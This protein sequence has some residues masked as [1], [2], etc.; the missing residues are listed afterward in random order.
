MVETVRHRLGTQQGAGV[1]NEENQP[2]NSDL[3][4]DMKMEKVRERIEQIQVGILR[5][6]DKKLS[7]MIEDIL[8]EI[9]REASVNSEFNQLFQ[10]TADT[11]HT[12]KK[13]TRNGKLPDKEFQARNSL[14][15]DLLEVKHIRTIY[16]IF[17]VIMVMTFLNTLTHD[18][19]DQGRI[20]I[21]VTPIFLGF[22]NLHYGV[23]LW[24]LMQA[25]TIKFDLA[26]ASA[27]ATLLEMTRL[28]MKTHAFVRSNVPRALYPKLK[29][30][31]EDK[32][33][34]Y[35]PE[36]GK[37]LY[38][39]FIPTLVYRDSYP[40]NKYIK[41]K[42]VAKCVLEIIGIVFYMSFIFE[43]HLIPVFR[44][45][46]TAQIKSAAFVLQI[47]GCMMP[48]ML[49]F[50]SGFYL[51]L[52]AWMNAFAEMLKFADRMFYQDW[53][54]ATSFP[55][56]Y[57]TWNVV[58]HDWL[59]TY[60]YKDCYEHIFKKSKIL[61]MLAVFTVSSFVHEY[62]IAFAFRFF[63]PVMLV[64]FQGMGVIVMFFTNKEKKSI[65][66][67]FM[68]FSLI[69]GNSLMLCLYNM[70][71][72]ARRNCQVGDSVIDYFIPISW[73]CNGIIKN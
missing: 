63:Y 54:N 13:T 51:L 34:F 29:A 39:L 40:R 23:M 37:F 16:H 72:N 70:E 4:Q 48:A 52:H 9:K 10:D 57:R 45:F 21:G 50:L 35:I 32:P 60:I 43:R 47:F 7:V 26:P 15:T 62:I 25:T 12:K 68:W 59:Y 33:E 20:N 42:F 41:W 46:G 2:Q 14:L 49:I 30:H 61:S 53:W 65:G 38:F 1:S 67:I 73:H 58:V 17:L 19:M 3:V 66:N 44:D 36:F 27:I 5:D 71:Y 64:L 24:A 28:L 22:R 6:V 18:F 55:E 69:L 31:T 56:Y 8:D 11:S